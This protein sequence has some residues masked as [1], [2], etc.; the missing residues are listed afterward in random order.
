[1]LT[2][3]LSGPV[4]WAQ[5]GMGDLVQAENNSNPE[6]K[7]EITKLR[8]CFDIMNLTQSCDGNITLCY[9]KDNWSILAFST[10]EN[11]CTDCNSRP[12]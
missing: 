8:I 12:F 4:V 7:T 6:L 5:A 10:T 3:C 11:M 2:V 1:M 9:A